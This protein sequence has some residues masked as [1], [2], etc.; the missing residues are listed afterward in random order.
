MRICSAI[1]RL[2]RKFGTDCRGSFAVIM[3]A[4]LAVLLL[5]AGF[6]VN[7]AQLYNVKSTLGHA[8]DA[9]V[10]STARDLTT[11]KVEPEDARALW[12]KYSSRPTA[13]RSS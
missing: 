11:S 8:L 6:A 2:V 7:L 3:G 5:S 9:A 10:T 1:G 12:S 4:I 13:I